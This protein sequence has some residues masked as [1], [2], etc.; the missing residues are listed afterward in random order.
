MKECFDHPDH[1]GNAVKR[2]LNLRQG[3]RS[4]A[5]F[6]EFRTLA[7]DSK[8]NDEDLKG[9]FLNGLSEQLTDELAS[10][11]EPTNFDY[12]VSL[13]IR[14]DN[15]VRERRRERAGRPHTPL[16]SREPQASP[17]SSDVEPMQLGR[18]CLSPT[19]QLHG[20]RAGEC[21]YCD[22]SGHFLAACPVW[23]KDMAHW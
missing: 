18:A 15:R 13:A 14:L 8:W 19:E 3:S 16:S 11:D 12:L 22:Q 20:M 1:G 10:R 17:I 9:A 21:L 4:V 6:V 2:L 5:D 23:P 7:A